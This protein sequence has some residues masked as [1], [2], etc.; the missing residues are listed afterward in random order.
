MADTDI[1]PET[2]LDD[3]AALDPA[4]RREVAMELRKVAETVADAP[5]KNRP[6]RARPTIPMRH[7]GHSSSVGLR[8]MGVCG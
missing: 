3:L 2:L 7:S 4:Q 5:P 1:T 8:D 6:T